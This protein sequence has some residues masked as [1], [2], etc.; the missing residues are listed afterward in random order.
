M[1]FIGATEAHT[2]DLD[3]APRRVGF[4]PWSTNTSNLEL[5][6]PNPKTGAR[7]SRAILGS[8]RHLVLDTGPVQVLNTGCHASN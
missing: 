8:S 4:K 5:P 3:K 1:N 7:G 2:D 6:A